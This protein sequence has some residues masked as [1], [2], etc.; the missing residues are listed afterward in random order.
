[1]TLDKSKKGML[2]K[3]LDIPDQLVRAQIIRFGITA[4]AT[5][6][7]EEIVP[8][9]PVIVSRNRQEIAIGRSL[10]SQIKI[11]PVA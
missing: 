10:A 7:C 11:E 4:G 2:V 9:G 1:M 6:T 8:G 5:V 3:I